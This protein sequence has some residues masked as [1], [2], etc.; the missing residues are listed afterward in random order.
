MAIFVNRPLGACCTLL[1]AGVVLGLF[2]SLMVSVAVLAV[3]AVG[4]LVSAILLLWRGYSHTKIYLL[5]FALGILLGVGRSAAYQ[6]QN[7]SL[8]KEIGN[9]VTAVF[10]VEE[11]SATNAYSAELLV[12]VQEING[13]ACRGK[14]V[15]MLD[16]ASPF[17]RGDRVSGSFG[18]FPLT[19]LSY[20]PNQQYQYM[21]K[22]CAV[23][24]VKET[25]QDLLLLDHATSKIT[26]FFENIHMRLCERLN[27]LVEGEAGHLLAA[28][29]LGERDGL[30]A[31]VTR[32]FRRAGVMHLLA[33]SGL[34]IGIIAGIFDRVL[35]ALGAHKKVRVFFIAFFMLG[36][37]FLT[38][39]TVSALR[40]VLMLFLIY[41]AFFFKSRAD[42]LTSLLLVAALI[43]LWQ[44]Y[45]IFSTSYQLTVLA[46]F[47]ILAF[48]RAQ[49]A[50]L[51]LLPKR[52]GRVGV[53][54]KCARFVVSSMLITLFA[55]FAVLPVQWLTFGEISAITPLSN[56]ILVPLAAPFL[57]L[58]LGVLFLY[59]AAPFAF[60]CR[61]MGDLMLALTAA[62]A[63]PETM[64]SLKYT[65]VP[66]LL[67]PC[68]LV[69]VVFLLIDLKK[70]WWLV[71]SPM[72]T[73]AIGFGICLLIT[74]YLCA[75]QLTVVYRA[76][77]KNEGLGLLGN[78]GAVL[79]DLSSTSASQL[80]N[81]WQM[82][83][84]EG[85][86][87][88]DVLM[89]THYHSTQKTSLARF[90]DRVTV[91]ALWLPTPQ[92][93]AEYFIFETLFDIAGAQSIPVILYPYDTA[94]TVF[95]K[96]AFYV[97]APIFNS[98]S[99][100]PAF[101]LTLSFGEK[102][103]YYQTAALSE[104]R[105]H[106]DVPETEIKADYYILGSHG[107]VPHEEISLPKG[108]IGTVL[109]PNEE[110]LLL[111][112][113]SDKPSYVVFAEKYRFLLQ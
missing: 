44:P 4:L 94:L 88:L 36:Y 49:T 5:L 74:R 90:L 82:L 101:A 39:C 14:A 91:R 20:H 63:K 12:S 104:Y 97:S 85:A 100:E 58:G 48:S 79:C 95:D 110:V 57:L 76:S 103:L 83:Q 69:A 86:T 38:G 84:E 61:A 41:L 24:L 80:Q 50:L 87:S 40:A 70:R 81:S 32:D 54:L 112:D 99:V 25:T 73:L 29:L 62:L 28:M 10:V 51:F 71:F 7:E 33:L 107:P 37:L 102:V 65:F 108:E 1:I 6:K 92:S 56:L 31:S 75:D 23:I 109:I 77:G 27:S 46:T 11:V 16:F 98:R 18:V 21:A 64:I 9:E 26:A 35:Y 19:H 68:I 15:L 111:L 96:G 66:Y 67:I 78:E 93:E 59:P 42:A 105:R 17:Y 60:A 43:L 106:A 34:H 30:S 13:E 113:I 8:T 3:A 89:L 47:G 72:L 52:G 22:G 53:L 2:C 55:G 45:A